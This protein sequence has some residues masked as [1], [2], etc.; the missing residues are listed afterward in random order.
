MAGAA[1]FGPQHQRRNTSHCKAVYVYGDLTS[2]LIPQMLIHF[3]LFR[4]VLADETT[5]YRTQGDNT[6]TNSTNYCILSCI[7]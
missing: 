4:F 1:Y 5:H 6:N 7:E 3:F 2:E